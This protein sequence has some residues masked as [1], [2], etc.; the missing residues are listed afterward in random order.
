[1]GEA[2]GV[3]LLHDGGQLRGDGGGGE[4]GDSGEAGTGT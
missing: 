3:D 4:V 1:V 2:G